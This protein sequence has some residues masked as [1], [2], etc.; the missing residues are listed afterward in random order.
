MTSVVEENIFGKIRGRFDVE[1]AKQAAK[2]VTDRVVWGF[3]SLSYED[4]AAAI[5]QFN[6]LHAH[7][8]CTTKYRIV[9]VTE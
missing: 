9:K 1:L 4:K 5:E 7:P 6:Q 3:A 8:H 2:E